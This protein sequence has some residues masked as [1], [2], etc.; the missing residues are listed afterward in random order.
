[1]A[2]SRRACTA[3]PTTRPP[4]GGVGTGLPGTQ[5]PCQC[6]TA[7]LQVAKQRVEAEPALIVARRTFLLGVSGDQRGVEVE[8]DLTAGDL[9]AR[10]AHERAG[11]PPAGPPAALLRWCPP[12]ARR[13]TSMPPRRTARAGRAARSGRPG[14]RRHRPALPPVAEHP[15]RVVR[16]AACP[17]RH[18]RVGVGLGQAQDVSQLDQ[19]RAAKVVSNSLAVGRD[20]TNR[21]CRLVVRFTCEVLSLDGC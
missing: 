7:A 6:L 21:V 11:A 16:R 2:D 19:R 10:P 5:H 20:H 18:H 1:M 8:H 13:S 9:V 15:T 14:N 4:G 3:T 17:G 12:P